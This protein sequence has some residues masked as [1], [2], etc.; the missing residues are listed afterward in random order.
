MTTSFRCETSL[1]ITQPARRTQL[2]LGPNYRALRTE[3]ITVV[4]NFCYLPA[5]YG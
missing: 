4:S 3:S 5:V 2:Q 1:S